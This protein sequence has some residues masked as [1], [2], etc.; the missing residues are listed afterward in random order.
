M[1]VG[2]CGQISLGSAPSAV[3]CHGAYNFCRFRYADPADSGG[4][5]SATVFGIFGLPSLRA[6]RDCGLM[7]ATLAAHE[8]T[9]DYK[10]NRVTV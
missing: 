1:L 7:V 10:R 6:S 9:D 5:K 2:Y 3:D 8:T 4:I